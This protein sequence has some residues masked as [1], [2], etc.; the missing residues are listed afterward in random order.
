MLSGFIFA[1]INSECDISNSHGF[2]LSTSGKQ[3]QIFAILQECFH[4]D[5]DTHLNKTGFVLY[6]VAWVIHN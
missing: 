2:D 1:I 5:A 3:Q 6:Y 4:E